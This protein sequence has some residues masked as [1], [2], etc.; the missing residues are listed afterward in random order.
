MEEYKVEPILSQDGVYRA[1]KYLPDLWV[2]E[3]DAPIMVRMFLFLEDDRAWLIDTGCGNGQISDFIKE[4]TDMP[5]TVVITHADLDHVGGMF[6]F[7]DVFMSPADFNH[8]AVKA[9]LNV[10]T[11]RP[12]PLWDS[13]TL[14]AGSQ[15]FE[16]ITTP[17][18][19]PGS[20]ALLDRKNR[21]IML[22]DSVLS[23]PV[24]MH[25]LGRNLVA[26]RHSLLMVCKKRETFDKLLLSHGPVV[27][28]DPGILD[29]FT[30]LTDK[31]MAGDL[32]PS[33]EEKKFPYTVYRWGRAAMYY[34]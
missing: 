15:R 17:G 5:V 4:L 12:K 8:C 31:V 16:V 9:G 7:E 26:Y 6:Q 27:E 1:F 24:H 2:I 22:G 14:G 11:N 13:D 23:L 19:T 29:E 30:I 20:I 21:L 18:H 3:Q 32:E 10:E 25:G 28:V 33:P 34:E